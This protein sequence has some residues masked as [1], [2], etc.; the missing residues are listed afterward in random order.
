MYKIYTPK[1]DVLRKHI[2]S[3]Y[4]M[5]AFDG[6]VNYLAFPQLGMTLALFINTALNFDDNVIV[7]SKSN[8]AD[9]KILLLGKYKIPIQLKYL[10]YVPEISINFTPTGLNYFFKENSCDI[11]NK[12]AQLIPNESWLKATIQIFSN[13]NDDDKVAALENFLENHLILKDTNI[14]DSYIKTLSDNPDETILDISQKLGVSTKTINRAFSRY[15]GCSPMSFKQILRFR[16][17]LYSKLNNPFENLTQI[18]FESN[19]Y[20]SPHF[21]REFKKL[22]HMSPSTF[23]SAIETVSNKDTPYKFL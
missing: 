21:I 18:G 20:D 22:T 17:A 8:K 2:D 14:A 6:R 4:V 11:A 10:G 15:I 5:K 1:S 9:A 13:T 19:F 23:F 7:I 3:I 16:K 12:K